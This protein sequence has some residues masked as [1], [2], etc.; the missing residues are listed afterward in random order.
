M[1]TTS[2]IRRFH[3]LLAKLGRM[4]QKP[5]ILGK[6]GVKSTKDLSLEQLKEINMKLDDFLRVGK[7]FK[8]REAKENE[9]EALKKGRSLVLKLATKAGIKEVDNFDKF[10]R[11]MLKSSVHH[12]EFFKYTADELNELIKQF[13]QILINNERAAKNKA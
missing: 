3:A 8:D 4:D 9:K 1:N 7:N 11:F 12:K 6:Y 2:E 10:N 13:R 5:V